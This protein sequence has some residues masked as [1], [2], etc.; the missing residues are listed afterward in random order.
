[1]TTGGQ[2][3]Q[4]DEAIATHAGRAVEVHCRRQDPLLG[5]RVERDLD[6]L[7]LRPR[8]EQQADDEQRD[9]ARQPADEQREQR[10]RGRPEHERAHRV[11]ERV[12]EARR[13]RQHE[14]R[15]GHEASP[16][17]ARKPARPNAQDDGPDERDHERAADRRAPSAGGRPVRPPLASRRPGP[18]APDAE[19]MAAGWP[20]VSGPRA[21]ERGLDLVHLRPVRREVAG[22]ERRLGGL[23]VGVGVLH[24]ARDVGRQPGVGR[25]RAA[26]A[27]GDGPGVATG[28]LGGRRGVGDGPAARLGLRAA[29]SGPRASESPQT[30]V[31]GRRHDDLLELR[32]RR[33]VDWR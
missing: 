33:G 18:T 8:P 31:V 9:A 27:R 3:E 19:V 24:E 23:E 10:G 6:Q 13:R 4:P 20:P 30:I 29:A 16:P 28:R 25:R 15:P 5:G 7:S 26:V 12:L 14:D 17:P 32:E 2:R 21:R 11:A 22:P 1:M